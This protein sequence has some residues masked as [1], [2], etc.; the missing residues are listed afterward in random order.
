MT[1]RTTSGPGSASDLRP[2]SSCSAAILFGAGGGVLRR[3]IRARPQLDPVRADPA[4]GPAVTCR[5]STASHA[6]PLRRRPHGHV[7]CQ[8]LCLLVRALPGR[9]PRA[10]AAVEKTRASGSSGS[11]TRTRR[12]N[13]R[14]FLTDLGNPYTAIGVDTAGRASIDWGVYGVPETFVVGPDGI[15]DGKVIGPLTDETIT[16]IR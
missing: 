6:G 1:P 16:T 13:A 12:D 4:P 8:R 7:P 5:R 9:A 2:L 14:K 15:I 3:L 10:G 11:T